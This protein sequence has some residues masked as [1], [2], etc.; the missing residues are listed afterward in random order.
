MV[1]DVGIGTFLQ[2]GEHILHPAA[3]LFIARRGVH[4][5]R[6]QVVTAHVAV[7]AVPV[8][9]GLLPG[10]QSG[11]DPVG[12]Q[13]PVAVVLQQGPDVE[14]PGLLQGAVEEFHIAQG[15]LVGIQPVL[16]L[17]GHGPR[18]RQQKER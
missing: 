18:R 9:I 16:G 6:G 2:F 8:G 10:L 4:R 17:A 12:G 3:A 11:L 7:Q 14:V 13:E 5:H 1:L 15:E